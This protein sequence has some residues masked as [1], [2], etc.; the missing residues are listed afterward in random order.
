MTTKN[1]FSIDR[2]DNNASGNPR[3]VVHFLAFVSDIGYDVSKAYQLT[4]LRCKKYG[5][6]KYHNKK[7]GGGICFST[8][9]PEEKINQIIDDI[10]K[11][12]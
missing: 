3:Y 10:T 4:I 9:T 12:V 11:E 6:K 7:Y 2:I 5:G 1:G 8:Y